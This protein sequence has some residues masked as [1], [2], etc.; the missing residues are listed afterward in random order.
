MNPIP[1]PQPPDEPDY[2]QGTT[3]VKCHC[4]GDIEWAEAA[5]APGAR[6]CRTCLT[7]FRV[8]GEGDTRRLVPQWPTDDGII[9]DAPSDMPHA[10]LYRVSENLYPGW[11]QPAAGGE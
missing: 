4:G 6:A 11:H 9:D 1:I 3:G 8:R 10:Y 2:W 7:L 5:Y